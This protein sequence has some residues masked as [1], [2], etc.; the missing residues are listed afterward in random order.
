MR[1]TQHFDTSFTAGGILFNEFEAILP[2]LTPSSDLKALKREVLENKYISIKTLGARKRVVPQLIK[3]IQYAPSNFW[4]FYTN[5]QEQERKLSLYFLC[6]KT[7]P[8][9]FALHWEVARLKWAN[10]SPLDA[11]AVQMYLDQLQ[12]TQHEVANWSPATLSK[13]NTQFRGALK[14]CGLLN[15]KHILQRPKGISEWF[16]NYFRQTDEAWFI[17]ACFISTK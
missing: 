13:I 2:L 7:Y 10:G 4:E 12:T 1:G 14:N 9:V 6:L 8:I 3:R 5:C 16:W 15:K 17:T 11:Y